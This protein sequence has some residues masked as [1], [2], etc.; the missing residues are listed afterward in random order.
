M[1]ELRDLGTIRSK[2]FVQGLEVQVLIDG[3]SS[4]SFIQSRIAKF[5]KLPIEPAP[6]FRVMVG[7]FDI[8]QVEGCVPALEV[9]MQ[10]HNLQ[11]PEVYVL[12]VAEGDLVIGA[13][14]LR[15]LKAHIADYDA[16][17]V[18]FLHDGKFITIKGD[19]TVSP[20]PTQFNHIKRIFHIDAVAEAFMVQ[21]IST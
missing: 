15:T 16:L 12:Q 7:N 1:K 10:G 18:R 11:I 9:S 2:A 13:T 4:D 8:M 14:W 6:G 5:L 17:L 20:Q 21:L 19:E 3:G